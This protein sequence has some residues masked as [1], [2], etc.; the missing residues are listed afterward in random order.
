M[1]FVNQKNCLVNHKKMPS[2]KVII[3]TLVVIIT[4]VVVTFYNTKD[5][6]QPKYIE[7]VENSDLDETNDT[8]SEDKEYNLFPKAWG[9][10]SMME[11]EFHS[12]APNKNKW[13]KARAQDASN[14]METVMDGDPRRKKMGFSGIHHFVNAPDIDQSKYTDDVTWGDSEFRHM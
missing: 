3:L 9:E 8:Q 1:L 2:M 4:L 7:P 14:M 6:V 5:D 12:F 10:E 13:D 11:D